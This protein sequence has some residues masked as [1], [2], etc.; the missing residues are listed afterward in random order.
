MRS[1]DTLV[2]SL[3]DDTSPDVLIVGGGINGIGVFRDLS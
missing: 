1:R 2:E 3:T